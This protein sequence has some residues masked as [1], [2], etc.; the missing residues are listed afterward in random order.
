MPDAP[1]FWLL[2]AVFTALHLLATLRRRL[3]WP[4]CDWPM[5]STPPSLPRTDAFRIRLLV[6]TTATWWK[7]HYYYR[8]RNFSHVVQIMLGRV[9]AGE[10]PFPQVARNMM[11]TAMQLVRSDCPDVEL[12]SVTRIE[13]V[14]L[15]A[16]LDDEGRQFTI[17]ER[18]VL[19]F[20]PP[21]AG[22]QAMGDDA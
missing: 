21:P 2:A 17:E 11:R 22:A 15:S 18:V 3:I 14:K 8:A 9:R 1:M 19:G 13:I 5:F 20:E 10:L 6:G 7:P 12:T 16:T 4:F